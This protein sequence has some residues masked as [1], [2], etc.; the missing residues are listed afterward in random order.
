MKREN[1][2]KKAIDPFASMPDAS[3]PIIVFSPV[4]S[5]YRRIIQTVLGHEVLVINDPSERL[6]LADCSYKLR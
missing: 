6:Q 1:R 3:V 4:F 2:G 5:N